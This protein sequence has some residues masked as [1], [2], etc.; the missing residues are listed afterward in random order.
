MH[1]YRS[2]IQKFCSG[3]LHG[4]M[5][6]TLSLRESFWEAGL[7]FRTVSSPWRT[8]SQGPQ[9]LWQLCQ[10]FCLHSFLGLKGHYFLEGEQ[11]P[12]KFSDFTIYVFKTPF[13]FQDTVGPII[14]EHYHVLNRTPQASTLFWISQSHTPSVHLCLPRGEDCGH[15]HITV[16][17]R[18]LLPIFS[19][20]T[21][22]F[23]AK[24]TGL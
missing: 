14:H 18:S 9:L 23:K 4:N 17:A 20:G 7:L 5:H 24:F 3:E 22:H 6:P 8:C 11:S 15:L 2:L 16:R 13:V 19:L 21:E 1:L 10:L 12:K